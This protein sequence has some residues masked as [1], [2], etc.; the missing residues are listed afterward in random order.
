MN[1]SSE[2][3]LLLACTRTTMDSLN[4]E[5]ISNL[6]QQEAI[7]WPSVK[8]LAQ[9]HAVV[10]LV[11]HQLDRLCPELAINSAVAQLGRDFRE[12]ARRNLHLSSH[13]LRLSRELEQEGIPVVPYK[14][15][16]LAVTVYGDLALRHAGD[17]DLLV[18]RQDVWRAR[19]LLLSRGYREKNQWSREQQ[20]L[21]LDAY[22]NFQMI[23]EEP[24]TLVE[25]HW[26]FVPKYYSFP[27]DLEDLW[28]GLEWVTLS[29]MEFRNPAPADLLL[30]LCLHGSKHC[31]SRLQWICDV[32]ELVRAYPDSDWGWTMEWADAIGGRRMIQ[33]GL[34]LAQD[35]LGAALPDRLAPYVLG[36]S[37]V[38][39]LAARVRRYLFDESLSPPGEFARFL[40]QVRVRERFRDR[41]RNWFHLAT[42]LNEKD[43]IFLRLPRILSFFYPLTRL[44]RL[45]AT[46][47]LRLIPPSR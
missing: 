20:K 29:N 10:P 26:A 32:A 31:W 47:T 27:L 37:E 28:P 36:D 14:G 42:S 44:L 2:V 46:Y 41:V 4:A 40:F 22:F 17:L 5:R 11:S 45:I 7:D 6:V 38:H 9:Q 19:D 25:I 12:N 24:G 13:F 1:L 23:H 35:L 39:L 18:R 34:L 33:L 21:V 15:P 8:R 30:L 3:Q 43:I 16:A